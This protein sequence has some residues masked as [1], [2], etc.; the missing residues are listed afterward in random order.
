[1]GDF[2]ETL[3]LWFD[4]CHR[5][6]PWRGTRDPYRIWLSEIMLQ[7][8]RVDTVRSYYERFLS[9]FSDVEALAAAP[10]EEVLKLW[11]GLGYYS[12]ARSLHKAAREILS[13]YGGVF[14]TEYEQI[15]ALPGIGPYTAGAVASIAFGRR[16]PAIDGNVYRVAARVFG[17]RESVERPTVQRQIHDEVLARMPENR[18]GDY[19]QA[20]MELGATCCCPGTPNCAACPVCRF[21]DAFEAED[22]ALLPVHE[23]KA[24]PKPVAV[25]VCLLRLNGKMLVVRRKERLLQGLYVFALLE[26]EA[27]PEELRAML[28]RQGL[29]CGELTPIGNA[30]HVF[31]HRVWEMTLYQGELTA[32]PGNP[33]TKAQEY[34]F[35]D[36]A[37]LAALPFPPP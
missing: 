36:A 6:M 1:M 32:P 3:L 16:V 29:P 10:E 30:R 25:A 23:R 24:P 26:E 12:R 9:H 14:P 7:Q 21:C 19:N 35:V 34:R 22:A 31:T 8:T 2:S 33:F 18:P 37:E 27:P 15:L 11:Q 20:L 5:E 28:Q 4:R 17:I 13:R